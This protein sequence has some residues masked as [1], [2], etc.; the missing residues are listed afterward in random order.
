[1]N[2]LHKYVVREMSK[3]ERDE[4][5]ALDAMLAEG[6]RDMRNQIRSDLRRLRNVMARRADVR[7]Q[8]E[9]L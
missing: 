1:M 9:A 5:M 4:L 3:K 8:L 6:V 7:K 2:A